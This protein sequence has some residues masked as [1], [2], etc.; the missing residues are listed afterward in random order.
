MTYIIYRKADGSLD[1]IP[2]ESRL[3]PEAE[4]SVVDVVDGTAHEAW[5]RLKRIERREKPEEPKR[6]RKR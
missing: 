2:K 1:C 5:S 6:R 4:G 3:Y